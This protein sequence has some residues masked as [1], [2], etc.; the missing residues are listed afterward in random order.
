MTSTCI[1]S[2]GGHMQFLLKFFNEMEFLVLSLLLYIFVMQNMH[3][4]N[5]QSKLLCCI[6]QELLKKI[7]L[8]MALSPKIHEIE[9]YTEP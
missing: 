2:R 9:N 5:I 7:H 6:F 1:R 3:R 8:T 4:E